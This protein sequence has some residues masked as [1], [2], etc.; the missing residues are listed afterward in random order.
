MKFKGLR[1]SIANKLWL[2]FGIISIIILT[3][4]G[5]IY[6]TLDKN[7]KLNDEITNVSKPSSK[8]ILDLE[9][10]I[11]SSQMLIKNWV[12]IDKQEG[13]SDK[14]KLQATID[15]IYPQIKIDLQRISKYWGKEEAEK[16][17][18]VFILSEDTLFVKYKYIMESLNGFDN[19]E[20]PMVMFEV[21]PMVEAGGEVMLIADKAIKDIH[22]IKINIDKI[23]DDQS[24][25]MQFSFSSFKSIVSIM[26]IVLIIL[27][28]VVSFTTIRMIVNP[29][30][31][32]KEI[33]MRMAKGILPDDEIVVKNDE[34]GDMAN[35]FNQH[36]GS[37]KEK[38]NFATN[39]GKGKFNSEFE[40]LGEEDVLGVELLEMKNSLQLAKSAE[41]KRKEEEEKRNW[42]V[43]GIGKFSEILRSNNDGIEKLSDEIIKNL[44]KYIGAIQGGVFLLND[45]DK[46]NTELE[47]ISAYAYDRKKFAQKNILLGEG[48]VG[49]CAIEKLPI[50]LTDIPN[51]Y[52]K[53]TS[54]LGDANPSVILIT[55]LK[56]EDKILGVI[57]LAGFNEIEAYKQDFVNKICESIASTMNSVKININTSLLL[58]QSQQQSEEMQAQEEEMRQ[59]LEEMQTTQEEVSRSKHL[60]EAAKKNLDNIG[61]AI[62]GIDTD[63]NINYINKVGLELSG[64]THDN[65]LKSKCYELW[66]N[67][68]CKTSECR[69]AIAMNSKNIETGR[70]VIDNSGMDIIYTGTAILDDDGVVTGAIEEIIQT[71]RINKVL[72]L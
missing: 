42:A 49:T 60:A 5:V 50:Y 64:V 12:F 72:N 51:D 29:I 30:N 1:F 33:A 2:G 66:E 6:L 69:C 56:I 14:I 40:P 15:S 52:V 36:I 21:Q 18:A 45:N 65:A 48:L 25:D 55:P 26:S 38:A 32:I 63:F 59:N 27:T 28:I 35:A 13:T 20:D 39:I 11:V 8:M 54:G 41:E 44:V 3:S 22:N 62:I 61:N 7:I 68:H 57:E 67:S 16:L 31:F 53:I 23:A 58:E 47:L 70:T 19:Y 9:N 10:L 4:L 37:L 24:A 17:E 71:S 34:I 46:N 43:E